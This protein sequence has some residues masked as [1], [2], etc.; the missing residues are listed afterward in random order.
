LDTFGLQQNDAEDIRD[1]AETVLGEVV[2]DEPDEGVLNKATKIIKG[3]LAP[4]AAGVGGAVAS[5]S[6]EAARKVIEAL[7]QS[8]S[9]VN[10][11]HLEGS[12]HGP[13]RQGEWMLFQIRLTAFCPL[14]SRPS[15]I[16]CLLP[17]AP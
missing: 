14:M 2:K 11:A 6:A 3:S 15:K 9:K 17:V 12:P 1:S 5:E 8:I 16:R 4:I 10:V 13:A 7:G